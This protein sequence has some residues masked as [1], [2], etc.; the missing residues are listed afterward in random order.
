MCSLCA[1]EAQPG[2]FESHIECNFDPHLHRIQVLLANQ[3]QNLEELTEMIVAHDVPTFRD[4]ERDMRR[5]SVFCHERFMA[6][7]TCNELP[8]IEFWLRHRRSR[9]RHGERLLEERSEK[10]KFQR[11]VFVYAG[12][13]SRLR[14]VLSSNTPMA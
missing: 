9:S 4:P 13:R 5:T 3:A 11:E 12:A 14:V 2:C 7:G 1:E 6:S 10:D 8:E